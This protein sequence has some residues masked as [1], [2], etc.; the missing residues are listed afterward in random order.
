[1]SQHAP[2]TEAEKGRIYQAKRDG[3]SLRL[4]ATERGCSMETVRKW[5]RRA[6]DQGAEGLV[7]PRRGR[8]PRGVGAQFDA[9]V[10]E[11]AVEVKRSH[12]KWGADRVRLRLDEMPEVTGLAIP[13]HSQ[14][15]TLFKAR[16]PECVTVRQ[17]RPPPPSP[18][19]SRDGGACRVA[20]G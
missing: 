4:I 8:P 10:L 19:Q 18:T 9:R 2:L 15:A 14:L 16:C 5:W 1:M 12:P 17:W 11:A 7:A 6:R 3:L 20:T 13:H